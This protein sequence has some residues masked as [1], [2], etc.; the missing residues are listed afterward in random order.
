LIGCIFSDYGVGMPRSRQ[1]S[2]EAIESGVYKGPTWQRLMDN[3]PLDSTIIAAA[4]LDLARALHD[5]AGGG[6][7]GSAALEL[8]QR[9]GWSEARFVAALQRERGRTLRTALEGLKRQIERDQP[10]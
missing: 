4:V 2:R 3:T 7:A 10:G 8:W 9:S 6:A 1:L 5:E